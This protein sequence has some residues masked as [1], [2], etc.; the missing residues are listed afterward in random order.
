[1]L[2]RPWGPSSRFAFQSCLLAAWPLASGSC[3]S[4]PPSLPPPLLPS[5]L[6]SFPASL[7]ARFLPPSL[8]PSLLLSLPPSLPPSLPSAFFHLLPPSQS[9]EC[10][11]RSLL[12]TLHTHQKHSERVGWQHALSCSSRFPVGFSLHCVKTSSPLEDKSRPCTKRLRCY[13]KTQATIFSSTAFWWS[14]LCCITE[15]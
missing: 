6:F 3:A 7:L 9:M 11:H 15:C 1:M 14:P 8:P 13:A 5:F 12:T 4:F 2:G 10:P